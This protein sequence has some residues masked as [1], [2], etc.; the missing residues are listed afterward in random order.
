MISIVGAN[1]GPEP[2]ATATAGGSARDIAGGAA[3]RPA[4]GLPPLLPKDYDDG[5]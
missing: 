3:M 2:G 1:E 5:T 4:F